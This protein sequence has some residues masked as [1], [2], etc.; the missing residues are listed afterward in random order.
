[1][2]TICSAAPTAETATASVATLTP[3]QQQLEADIKDIIE[4]KIADTIRADGGDIH[5]IQYLPEAK[6]VEIA[7]SG[8]CE[9]CDRSAI[10]LQILV[11]NALKHYFPG[12]IEKVRRVYLPG[13]EPH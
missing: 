11:T 4:T 9:S 13:Q 6:V 12:S 1:M 8:A 3:E 10:T 2:N 5:F 7:L